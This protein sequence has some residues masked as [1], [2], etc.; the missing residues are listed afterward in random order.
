MPHIPHWYTL[1]KTWADDAEFCKAVETIRHIGVWRWWGK[2]HF[3][4]FHANG[5][6]YW[7]MGAPVKDTILIN[8]AIDKYASAD[9]D[10][11]AQRYD[12]LY[13]TEA[14]DQETCQAFETCEISRDHDVLDVGCGTGL[15]H[16]FSIP[17]SSYVGID[18]SGQMLSIAKGKHPDVDYLQ[19]S[20]EH[21]HTDLLFDR[22]LMLFT[23]PNHIHPAYIDKVRYMLA[24]GGKAYLF[25]DVPDSDYLISY[26][27]ELHLSAGPVGL[28]KF[29]QRYG[30]QVIKND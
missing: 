8:R 10:S 6:Y 17:C 29:N 19:C 5:V 14:H 27:D 26:E 23:V 13:A 20:F 3:P 22:I 4:Y 25:W 15:F 12:S 16:D 30:L 11:I 21:Y 7:S 2:Y 24:P 18:P 1:R 9:Y 28:P